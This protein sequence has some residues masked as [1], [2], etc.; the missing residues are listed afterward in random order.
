VGD[1][2]APLVVAMIWHGGIQSIVDRRD[3]RMA[4]ILASFHAPFRGLS[5]ARRLAWRVRWGDPREVLARTAA[6]L[7]KITA[8]TLI[9]HGRSDGAIPETFSH[10]AAEVLS[11]AR[12]AVLETGHFLPLNRPREVAGLLR[13]FL[14]EFPGESPRG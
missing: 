1:L 9:L 11:D 14:G 13:E 6:C 3:E 4:E 10:R 2:L 5:G 7:P 12:V 8:P